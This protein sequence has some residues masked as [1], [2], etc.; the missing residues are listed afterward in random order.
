M[1]GLLVRLK[2]RLLLNAL[3]R[4]TVATATFLVSTGCAV[5]VACGAFYLLSVQGGGIG[6]QGSQPAGHRVAGDAGS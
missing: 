1:V 3:R 4:S 5:L 2:L 6:R